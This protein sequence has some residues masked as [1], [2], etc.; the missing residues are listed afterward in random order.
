VGG[1]K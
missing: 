1:V